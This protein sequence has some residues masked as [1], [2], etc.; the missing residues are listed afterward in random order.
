MGPKQFRMDVESRLKLAKI[1]AGSPY[2]RFPPLI[3]SV[4]AGR[5]HHLIRGYL[6]DFDSARLR[7]GV[8]EAA[9]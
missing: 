6:A 5:F 4:A 7:P 1:D 8:P 3:H 2:C 9:P